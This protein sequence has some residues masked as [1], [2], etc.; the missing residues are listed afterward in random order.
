MLMVKTLPIA[1]TIRKWTLDG[2]FVAIG[3]LATIAP[4]VDSSS[5]KFYHSRTITTYRTW[6]RWMRHQDNSKIRIESS[7]GRRGGWKPNRCIDLE[8]IRYLFDQHEASYVTRL[9]QRLVLFIR[10]LGIGDTHGDRVAKINPRS[11]LSTLTCLFNDFTSNIDISS[12]STDTLSKD[13][14]IT[15]LINYPR[16][17]IIF[18]RHEFWFT[19][20]ISSKGVAFERVTMILGRFWLIFFSFFKILIRMTRRGFERGRRGPRWFLAGRRTSRRSLGRLIA[21]CQRQVVRAQFST[22]TSA[23]FRY[24]S[25]ETISKEEH[26]KHPRDALF[27]EQRLFRLLRENFELGRI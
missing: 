23:S 2:G 21:R 6:V 26:P 18:F 10:R 19:I 15:E 24:S 5:L 8:Y 12:I 1:G 14:L 9:H 3:A 17:V 11:V 20:K 22:S 13:I 7:K 4:H 27:K 25:K 16:L